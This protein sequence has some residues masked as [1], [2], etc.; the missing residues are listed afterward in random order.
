MKAPAVD[1]LDVAARLAV[2]RRGELQRLPAERALLAQDGQRA[3][4]VAAVQRQRVIEDV[5]DAHG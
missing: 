2:A 3:E 1:V 4:R 5:Q